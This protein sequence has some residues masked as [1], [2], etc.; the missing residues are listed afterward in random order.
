V[1][2]SITSGTPTSGGP[3]TLSGC[4]QS[5]TSGVVTFSGCK[6]D[7][8]GTGYKLHA[9]DGTLT[10]ADSAAFNITVGPASQIALS[11][12]TTNLAS[13]STRTFTATIQ[14]AGGNTVTTGADSTVSVTFSQTGGTGSVTGTG[15]ATASGGVAT[16]TVTGNVAGTV[17]LQASAT[18]SGPGATNSNTLSFTVTGPTVV[19]VS[20]NNKTGGT[21]GQAEAGDTIVITYSQT[22]KMTSIC[23]NSTLGN[24]S[25][26]SITPNATSTTVTLTKSSGTD[27]T[28]GST[29]CGGS[30]H[31]GAISLKKQYVTGSGSA[32][33][34]FGGSTV[35]WNGSNTIT[36]TLGSTLGGTGTLAQVTTTDGTYTPD[37][38]IKDPANNF[39]SGTFTWSAVQ[40]F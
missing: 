33:K 34:S 3:G 14:D 40:S 25:S 35:S 8:A 28:F 29:D 26:G 38:T 6:I 23:S 19:S 20:I 37:P 24:T 2:L 4:T 17:N 5:E 12:T 16:K 30:L 13:G 36:I 21:A 27:V 15:A 11:G 9:I 39:I 18:L 22:L 31:I 1:T 7:T 10:A 32:N